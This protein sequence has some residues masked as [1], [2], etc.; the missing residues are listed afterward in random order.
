MPSSYRFDQP[1]QRTGTHSIK[2]DYRR[3]FFGQED[4]WPMWVADMDFASPPEVQDALMARAGHGIYGYTGESR[5]FYDGLLGWL[6]ERH[7]WTVDKEWLKLV[8]GVIPALN[9]CVHAF[10]APGDEVI[11]QPPIYPPFYSCVNNNDRRVVENPLRQDAEGRYRM[12]LDHLESQIGPRT[13]MLIFCSPHN[14]VGRVWSEEELQ[15]LGALCVKYGLVLVSDEIHFDL[16]WS[17]ARHRPMATLAG[18]I[19]A[20]TVTLSSPAKTFNLQGLQTGFA[21]IPDP[22]LRQ[23]YAKVLERNGIFMQNVMSLA[24]IAAAYQHGA[25]WLEAL[26]AYLADNRRHLEAAVE[27]LPGIRL[28]P[29]EGTYL[30][31]LDCRELGFDTQDALRRFFIEQARLGLNDGATF[32]EAGNGFMRLNYGC[33]R[34]TLDEGLHRLREALG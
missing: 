1:I 34:S 28:T 26:K 3:R 13:K 32:G 8:P 7:G 14:P 29:A 5:A 18:D 6:Q 22:A 16:V 20:R 24:A 2:W 33:P 31:W 4:V 12:D 21:V 11:I 17:A 19:Q 15:A 9:W 30:A 23:A 25:P 10:T 27:T